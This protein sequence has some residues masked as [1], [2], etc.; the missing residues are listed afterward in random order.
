MRGLLDT[1]ET[2]KQYQKSEPTKS[3]VKSSKMEVDTEEPT[4]MATSK[5]DDNSTKA[6]GADEGER[7]KAVKTTRYSGNK[8]RNNQNRNSEDNKPG[9]SRW[10]NDKNINTMVAA[11]KMVSEGKFKN[12]EEAV[13]NIQ[14]ATCNGKYHV[15]ADCR[16]NS[17][18]S[19]RYVQGNKTY[20][21]TNNYNNNTKARDVYMIHQALATL[22]KQNYEYEPS[23]KHILM[24]SE[25][26][27]TQL[28]G[29]R[30]YHKWRYNIDNHCNVV[31]FNNSD[32][33]TDIKPVQVIINGYG[34]Q[35]TIKYS[36]VHKIFGPGYYDPKSPYNLLGLKPLENLI[37]GFIE[38]K[39]KEANNQYTYLV[40]DHYGEI[41]FD[42]TKSDFYTLAHD[43]LI[44]IIQHNTNERMAFAT[45]QVLD[46]EYTDEEI[47]KAEDTWQL[48][49]RLGHPSNQTLRAMLDNNLIVNTILTGHDVRRMQSIFGNCDTCN[50]VKPIKVINQF[51]TYNPITY[52]IGQVMHMD[53]VFLTKSILYLLTVER[54]T[55]YLKAYRITTKNDIS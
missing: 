17:T 40:H 12:L 26:A 23:Q 41:K 46:K 20:S 2:N 38:F 8:F 11:T 29:M 21:R 43:D 51:P 27:D 33:V 28:S 3:T 35:S 6:K 52:E 19:L 7:Q 18:E 24:V 37:L 13:R 5:S 50:T 45:I 32:L 14:C 53:I 9:T 1:E 22:D 42:R 10:Y 34:G 47:T 55:N 4:A 48:H 36:C 54:M 49:R 25:I 44:S 30:Q 16:R 15:Q 39:P 31:I